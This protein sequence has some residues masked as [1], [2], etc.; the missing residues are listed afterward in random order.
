MYEAADLLYILLL[1][2]CMSA[3]NFFISQ[4]V[5]RLLTRRAQPPVYQLKDRLIPFTG[6][7][8]ARPTSLV[9]PHSIDLHAL[10][11]KRQKTEEDDSPA[12]TGEEAAA[13]ALPAA[14][15]DRPRSQQAATH[16]PLWKKRQLLL[17]HSWPKKKFHSQEK[18]QTLQLQREKRQPF[19]PR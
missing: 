15:E 10:G 1:A 8:R 4:A 9:L 7:L 13:T 2:A 3:V 16:R 12:R 5:A 11:R 17:L 18:K 19:L 14:Q 6:S